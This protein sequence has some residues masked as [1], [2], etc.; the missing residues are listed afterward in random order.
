M[1]VRRGKGRKRDHSGEIEYLVAFLGEDLLA[2]VR[3]ISKVTNQR[4]TLSVSGKIM[5]G[6]FKLSVTFNGQTKH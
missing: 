1:K 5:G 6:T 2:H 3:R 4:E